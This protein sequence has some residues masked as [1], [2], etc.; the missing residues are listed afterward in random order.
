MRRLFKFGVQGVLPLLLSMLFL[1]A[2]TGCTGMVQDELDETH[3]RLK[4][5]QDVAAVANNEL[6]ALS[7]IV[8]LLDDSHTIDP[9]SLKMTEEGYEVTFRDGKTIVIP[10]GKDG[11]DG[12][13]L[14]PVGVKQDE[15]SLY[16]WTVDGEWLTDD[17]G[18]KMRAGATDGAAGE[19]GADGIV[20]QIKVEDG[21]WWISYDEWETKE[22]LASCDEMNGVGVFSNID[23]SDT[24][25]LV[26]TLLDGTVLEIPYY[27]AIKISFSGA[28][29]D[30]VLIGAGEH[31][32]IPYEVLVEGAGSEPVVV[33][34]G[35]D[36]VYFS[37]IV[38]GEQPGKGTVLVQAPEVFSEGYIFLTAYCGGFSAVKMI[39]FEGRT[40]T[41]A[42]DNVTVRLSSGADTVKVAYLTNFDYVVSSD[43]TW[44][45]VVPNPADST[46]TFISVPNTAD[47]VRTGIVTV[48]PKDNPD[49]VCTTFNVM[50][51]TDT[52]VKEVTYTL[53]SS[54]EDFKFDDSVLNKLTL[55]APAKGGNAS[56]WINQKDV[57]ITKC[58]TTRIKA[59]II[60]DS[61][62][63]TLS[64]SVG[65]NEL[66][67]A[68]KDTVEFRVRQT[69]VTL[70]INQAGKTT[71]AT[72]E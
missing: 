40:V 15:D 53:D 64:L 52:V 19:A 59:I 69:M 17:E 67:T 24:S 1:S 72:G 71:E 37:R 21:S 56:I 57:E 23:T 9:V 46:L 7:K 68:R 39:S 63:S 45:K 70:E 25:K 6:T 14:I 8:S 62:G 29:I 47:T 33:T 5:L 31:L 26:L 60:P 22:E 35:T 41:P 3:A 44:L 12:R 65:A 11:V 51:A 50:Q 28:Q 49:Y 58:D 38:G 42:A 32:P 48:S 36:G 54:D 2:L 34:S 16:Y 27:S 13:T 4:A 66:E 30:T 43:T 10:F 61:I 18:N 20:P 55:D